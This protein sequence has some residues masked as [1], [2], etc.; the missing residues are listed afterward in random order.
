[1]SVRNYSGH[2][3]YAQLST[4]AV[5]TESLLRFMTA[6]IESTESLRTDTIR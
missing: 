4:F 3:A 5:L 1:M 6:V 2:S